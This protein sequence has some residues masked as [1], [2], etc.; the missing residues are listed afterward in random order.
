[1]NPREEYFK[2]TEKSIGVYRFPTRDFE[3]A[4]EKAA[5]YQ[6]LVTKSVFFC[7]VGVRNWVKNLIFKG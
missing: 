1:L 6:Y 2:S 3:T 7:G 5:L 4:G